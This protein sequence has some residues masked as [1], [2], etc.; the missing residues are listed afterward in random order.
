MIAKLPNE[1]VV[2]LEQKP[3]RNSKQQG[4]RMLG[5]R[6]RRREVL[7]IQFSGNNGRCLHESVKLSLPFPE[8][9]NNPVQYFYFQSFW[10]FTLTI[11]ILLISVC[12]LI[13]Y[14]HSGLLSTV[15]RCRGKNVN[16]IKTSK[17]FSP[18]EVTFYTTVYT[19]FILF[20]QYWK[21]KGTHGI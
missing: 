9:K 7:G 2:S 17:L 12:V 18:S 19:R 8:T 3:N 20:F 6:S 14:L 13:Y 1:D 11:H 16:G 10:N 4:P 21:Y 15:K 5:Y